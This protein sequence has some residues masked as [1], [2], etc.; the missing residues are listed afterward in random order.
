MNTY[1]VIMP[2]GVFSQLHM[3]GALVNKP[4][5]EYLNWLCSEWLMTGYHALSPAGR[6][7]VPIVMLLC[8]LSWH[9]TACHQK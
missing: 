8:Q 9:G 5:K 2:G 7:K 6:I 1:V 3:L 4:L